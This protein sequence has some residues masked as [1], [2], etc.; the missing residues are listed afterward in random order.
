VLTRLKEIFQIRIYVFCRRRNT[1]SEHFKNIERT[2][3]VLL[4]VPVQVPQSSNGR[5]RLYY[6]LPVPGMSTISTVITKGD[7][8]TLSTNDVHLLVLV[9]L[10]VHG[11]VPGTILKNDNVGYFGAGTVYRYRYAP[12]SSTCTVHGIF[13]IPY[14][15]SIPVL[16]S[17]V[18][19]V[20]YRYSKV[21]GVYR[22]WYQ[23]KY[24][25]MYWNTGPA[26]RYRITVLYRA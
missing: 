8:A 16:Y 12:D 4:R 5:C 3:P 20:P 6:R 9:H 25:T 2:V 23:Y 17:T 14:R 21:Y 10:P 26:V 19:Y 24:S 22:E 13:G 18:P 15:K 1:G 7:R 11:R